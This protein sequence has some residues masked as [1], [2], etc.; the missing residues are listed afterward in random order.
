[1]KVDLH[2]HTRYSDGLSNLDDI[3][4]GAEQ[5]HVDMIAITDHAISYK[6]LTPRQFMAQRAEVDALRSSFK[7]KVLVGLEVEMKSSGMDELHK[8]DSPDILLLSSHELVD[9]QTYIQH[10]GNSLKNNS[11]KVLAHHRWHPLYPVDHSLDKHLVEL[12]KSYDVA[13]EINNRHHLPGDGFLRLCS[14]MGLRYTLGSDAHHAGEVGLMDWSESMARRL[15]DM[16][17]IY[18][19]QMP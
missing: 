12:L 8:Y 14:E 6:G 2:V 18:I 7:V 3:L 4:E 11:F 13:I 1:M 9:P 19:P 16:E 17:K 5:R 10:V 15:F